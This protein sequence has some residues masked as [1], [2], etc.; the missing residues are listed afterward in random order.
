LYLR[1]RNLLPHGRSSSF[2]TNDDQR[3]PLSAS[4]IH[5]GEVS[6]PSYGSLYETAPKRPAMP[7]F[8]FHFREHTQFLPTYPSRKHTSSPMRPTFPR[9]GLLYK[10]NSGLRRVLPSAAQH[11]RLPVSQ[12]RIAAFLD[13]VLIR[14]NPEIARCWPPF[15][16]SMPGRP[17]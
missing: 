5:P 14:R 4:N 15:R 10:Q 12:G 13:P 16:R 1:P 8:P 3:L 6:P 17:T 11:R 2:P 9:G 7:R